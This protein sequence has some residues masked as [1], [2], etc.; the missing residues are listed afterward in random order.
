MLTTQ[1]CPDDRKIGRRRLY[2]RG[3]RSPLGRR[4][5]SASFEDSNALTAT[6]QVSIGELVDRVTILRIKLD[7]SDHSN[8]L[9]LTAQLR[10]YDDELSRVDARDSARDLR[11]VLQR[12]NG[13]LWRLENE[14]RRCASKEQFDHRFICAA[15]LI[16]RLNERRARIKGQIDDRLKSTFKDTKSYM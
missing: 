7:R 14:V 13:V 2:G 9:Q 10:S 11:L 16:I 8:K 4:P 5:D 3:P 12:V 1:N 6:I 15:R